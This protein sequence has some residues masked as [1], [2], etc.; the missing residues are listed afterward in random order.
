[1]A[2]TATTPLVKPARKPPLPALTGIRTLLAFNIV[3][4]HFTPPYLG[5]I[6]PFVEHGF[7]FVNVFF[8]I[9][10]FILSYNYFDRGANLVKRDFWMA[11]FSRL[12]PVYLLVLLISF[13]MLELEWHARSASEFWQ[14][15]V[16]TPLL[17]QGWSPSLATFWNTVAWTLSCE[18]AFYAAFPWLIRLPWPRKPSRLVLAIF[19]LWVVDLIPAMLYLWLN[20]EHLTS[21][22]DR[23]TSTTLIRFLKYTPLPYA[24]TFLSGIALSR[25]Q[26]LVTVSERRRMTL[27]AIA[28]AG[29][30]LFFYLAAGHVPYLVLHGGLLLPL[31]TL[32]VFGLSGKHAIAKVFSWGPLLLVG[33]S[34]YCLYLLHFNLFVMIHQYHLPERL[35]VA[36][37]DPWISYAVLLVLSILI[38]KFFENP[39]RRAILNRF[40]PTSRRTA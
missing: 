31:F 10:G 20:P 29:L 15:L 5:P 14:G 24:P 33:E 21:P 7:V 35:H 11:R 12:Y 34:S 16:M 40:P 30:G 36:N 39:V 25:L 23:Y 27:A 9:S 22:V 6:R 8:L 1:M 18:M 4:F 38:Y 19:V 17:L 13:P 37:L 3:L 2:S 28:L 26:T 32:L